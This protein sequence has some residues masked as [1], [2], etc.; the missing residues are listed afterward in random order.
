[1]LNKFIL[2]SM[3]DGL[4][5]T[6][7]GERLSDVLDSSVKVDEDA[8]MGLILT[9]ELAV[10]I[11]TAVNDLEQ[12]GESEPLMFGALDTNN[13]NF[14]PNLTQSDLTTPA[15]GFQRL[16]IEPS[17]NGFQLLPTA[18]VHG[19]GL[20]HHSSSGSAFFD[21]MTG[22]LDAFKNG[23][24]INDLITQA[25]PEMGEV[26]GNGLPTYP[27]EQGKQMTALPGNYSE[28]SNAGCRF[29][30]VAMQST[31][32]ASEFMR[33]AK[34]IN[35]LSMGSVFS[36]DLVGVVHLPSDADGEVFIEK[37][38]ESVATIRTHATSEGF[39]YSERL[40]ANLVFMKEGMVFHQVFDFFSPRYKT[41][42]NL[43][44]PDGSE[45]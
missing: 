4:S 18:T 23:S 5:L 24:F 28:I 45:V 34:Y 7:F 3:S 44:A 40:M 36:E 19:V 22:G 14:N 39:Q 30:V 15:Y 42:W 21:I 2:I 26:Y 25:Q 32:P 8:E 43:I 29:S 13:P 10:S 31:E 35:E 20:G 41:A 12:S 27:L 17:G 6:K 16:V 1:M 33:R 9:D 11:R 38:M 37:F